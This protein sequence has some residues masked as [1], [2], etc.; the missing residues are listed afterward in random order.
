MGDE[1]INYFCPSPD[2]GQTVVI[3]GD[4]QPGEVYMA[5][6]AVLTG[7][8]PDLAIL[9]SAQVPIRK[10]WREFY[11]SDLHRNCP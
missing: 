9:E 2:A 11:T 8:M 4:L 5:H 10:L 1:R 7:N 3:L 6:R